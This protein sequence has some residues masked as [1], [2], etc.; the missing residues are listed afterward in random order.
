L[1]AIFAIGRKRR[2]KLIELP[3]L[4]FLPVESLILSPFLS[5]GP[6]SW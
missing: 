4:S 3:H 5:F 1:P 2:A 6:D